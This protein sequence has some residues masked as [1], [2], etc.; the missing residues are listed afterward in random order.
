MSELFHSLSFVSAGA[1]AALLSAVW[2]GAVLCAGVAICLRL[3]PR[4]SAAARSVVWFN[5]FV[6]VL[7]L[8]MVPA[9]TARVPA[10]SGNHVPTI[11]LDPRWSLAIAGLWLSLSL[12]RAVQLLL[13]AIHLR[14]LA[15]R[16]VPVVVAV[17]DE[18]KPL[19]TSASRGR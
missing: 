2:Q 3:L 10:L 1:S 15:D 16:A 19:L 11:H 7:L 9:F 5:V 8:H 13:G 18:L 12:W 4:L 6:L 14:R 17:D